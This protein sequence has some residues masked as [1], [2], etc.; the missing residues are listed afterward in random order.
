MK[1]VI[2]SENNI[3]Q[4]EARKNLEYFLVDTDRRNELGFW[5]R[6]FKEGICDRC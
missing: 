1:M 6:S 4:K 5:K 3:L 2:H